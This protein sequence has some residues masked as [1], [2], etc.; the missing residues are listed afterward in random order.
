MLIRKLLK[1]KLVRQKIKKRNLFFN[2]SNYFFED[3][4]LIPIYGVR[5]HI[6]HNVRVYL[7][8]YSYN[9]RYLKL[10]F[11]KLKTLSNSYLR[12]SNI[13]NITLI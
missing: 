4:I 7:K 12:I 9:I 8:K 13:N 11:F 2:Y 1:S 10:S 5:M 6:L 3:F